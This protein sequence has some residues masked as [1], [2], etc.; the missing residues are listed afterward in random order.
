MSP[1]KSE[2]IDFIDEGEEKGKE[3]FWKLLIVDDEEEVHQITELALGDLKMDGKY[4]KIISAFSA[5]EA[6]DILKNNDD[7]AIILLDVVME[8]DDAGLNVVKTIREDLK[9]KMVR[10]IIRTGAPGVAPK[11]E[12][13]ENY[14]I[15]DYKEKTELNFEKLYAAVFNNLR[16]F[17]NLQEMLRM[18]EEL[19][20]A[21]KSLA[22]E[23]VHLKNEVHAIVKQGSLIGNSE[24][25]QSVVDVL[26]YILESIS[27]VLILGDTGTGKEMIARY[28]HYNGFLGDKPF[29]T[30]NCA[31]CASSLLESELFGYAK[32]A[33]TGA[34]SDREGLF[35]AA[36]GGTLFLDEIGDMALEM[37][38]KVLRAIQFGE[39]KRLGET[40]SRR[41]TVR[42][43]AA[44]H[45][46][47]PEEIA[48]GRFRKDLYY[49]LAVFPII[50]PSL[51]KRIGDIP[52]LVNHFIE[53]YSE[54]LSKS[55]ISI[56]PEVL[57][58]LSKEKYRGNVR[59]LENKVERMV[60][61]V[62][63]NAQINMKT[64]RISR[65]MDVLS[66]LP[67]HKK[68]ESAFNFDHNFS[69]RGAVLDYEKKII[70]NAIE[71]CNGNKSQ[72]ARLLNVSLRTVF[73]KLSG[74]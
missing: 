56:A 17:K 69:L 71:V 55:G 6:L 18:S 10:I 36:N 14:D 49:R 35:E 8:T 40:K 44:T 21:N 60:N 63:P 66:E 25:W 34:I 57:D 59:E 1:K 31:S 50:L 52:L 3:S 61:I 30:V 19:R 9:N 7:I 38:A 27:N 42:L 70:N 15:S 12:I 32:G 37:Q 73:S 22:K 2:E 68:S 43:I 62:A 54:K 67:T 45:K 64:Y 58:K 28:I 13:I 16:A 53:K 72:A 41:V 11:K 51:N 39:V 47:L 24:A 65:R 33:F 5:K 26:K 74:D 23:N 46:N 20:L 48:L 4:L 29:V